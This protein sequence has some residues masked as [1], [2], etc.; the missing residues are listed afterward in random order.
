MG[1]RLAASAKSDDTNKGARQLFMNPIQLEEAYQEFISN[2]P[3]WIPEGI[4]E[5]NIQLLK[6]AGLLTYRFFDGN[7]SEEELPCYFHVIETAE[8]V[9]LFNHR[10]AIW[11]LPKLMNN[12]P[13]TIV[14]I[15]LMVNGKPHLENVFSTKGI[16]NTPKF[17]LKMI[18]YYLSEVIDTEEAISS[19]GKI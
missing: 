19:I 12:H 1:R 17:V 3:R 11:I 10:F 18:K 14:L 6:E 5:V 7:Q 9:T 2:F 4:I 8:K 13:T 15:A 16:Y